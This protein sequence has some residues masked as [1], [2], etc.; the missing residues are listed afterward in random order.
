[1]FGIWFW[2]IHDLKEERLHVIGLPGSV[3]EEH[4]EG[5]D[6]ERPDVALVGVVVFGEDLRGEVDGHS[7]HLLVAA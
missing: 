2:V 1:M 6:A 7:H 4:F 3:I 5:D